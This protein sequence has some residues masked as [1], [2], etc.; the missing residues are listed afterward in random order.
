MRS[1]SA[2]SGLG[3]VKS[4]DRQEMAGQFRE[5]E[6]SY[7][8]IQDRPAKYKHLAENLEQLNAHAGRLVLSAIGA[9]W[10][11]KS[12]NIRNGGWWDLKA[13][14]LPGGCL[15]S[16]GLEWSEGSEM[17]TGACRCVDAVRPAELWLHT[18]S[19]WLVPK[20]PD[21]FTDAAAAHD[22]THLLA[23]DDYGNP[24]E[25]VWTIDGQPTSRE[26]CKEYLKAHAPVEKGR[27]CCKLRRQPAVVEHRYDEADWLNR[28]RQQVWVRIAACRLLAELIDPVA[29][30]SP[31][32]GAEV[33]TETQVILWEGAE[34]SKRNI[35]LARTRTAY[36]EAH[37]NVRVALKA[38]QAEGNGISKSTFY[39]HLDA[40][41][42]E[43][44]GW[45]DRVLVSD[46]NGNPDNL[47]R[48]GTRGKTRGQVG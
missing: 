31:A 2:Q 16:G 38:L 42:R 21:R 25:Y 12:D 4:P 37:G 46:Q 15:L 45:R 3:P 7:E 13:G 36:S 33:R 28:G 27:V 6:K 39:S 48:A 30:R 43:I 41:D 14:R 1:K 19:S 10:F 20:F 34:H 29:L 40:L 8:R 44:P 26:A 24:L 47:R 35:R 17:P 22:W 5:L 11:K 9:G 18:L 23:E 32:G